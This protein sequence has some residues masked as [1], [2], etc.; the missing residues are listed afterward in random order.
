MNMTINT[1]IPDHIPEE[2]LWDHSLAAFVGELDDPFRAAARLHDGPDIIW[3]TNALLGTPSWIFTR[4][5][6]IRKA[7]SNARLFSSK[8]G[9]LTKAFMDPSWQMLPLEADPP[10][11]M[12]LRKLLQ[13]YFS[14]AALDERLTKVERLSNTLIDAFIDRGHCEFIEEFASILPNAIVV[15][16]LG[17]PQTML[18]QFLKWEG[19]LIHSDSAQDRLEAGNAIHDYIRRYV[20]DQVQHPSNDL[21]AAIAQGE[22]N[23]RPL[24]QQEK[25]GIVYLLFV[26]GL[27]TVLA[28]LGWVMNHLANNQALQQRLR[29]NPQDIP[30]AVEEFGRAFGVSAPSRVVA[31]DMVFEGVPMKKGDQLILPTYLAGR[32]PLAFPDPHVIDIN[33]NPTHATFGAGP[34]LCLGMHLAK[35]EMQIMLESFLYRM[36]NIRKKDG[37][38]FEFQTTGTISV[39]RLDLTWD[40]SNT[41]GASIRSHRSAAM[42]PASVPDH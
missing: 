39:S 7:F 41:K 16:M 24:S 38:R 4:H 9:P 19:T 3:T 10:E 34:H 18:Q 12:H 8:R 5:A 42:I 36:K 40:L 15:D 13:P 29:N 1:L 37:G 21:M 33:R 22:I 2:N 35:R 25:L 28:S 26:A 11:H 17:M 27:D 23:G 30:A 20:A 6:L 14:P 31:E 32:D